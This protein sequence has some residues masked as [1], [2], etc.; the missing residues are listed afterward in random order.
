MSTETKCYAVLSSKGPLEPTTIK[1][2]SCGP[3]DIAVS[4]KYAGICHS[5]IHT[6][7]EE[8]G[9]IKFPCVPGH[10]IGGIV[11]AVGGNVKKFKAGDVVGVGCMV[12]SCRSCACCKAS[13]E[14]YCMTGA[15]YTYNGTAKYPHML[16][17][18][19]E[20]GAVTYGGYSQSIVVD[21]EFVVL[22]PTN[23]NLAAATPLLCAGIT[24]YSPMNKFGLK[25]FHK[26]GVVGL[27]GLGHMAVKF[28]KAFGCHTTVISRGSSKKENCLKEL[29]AHAFLDSTS[30]EDMAAAANSFDF[31]LDT[32]SAHHDLSS[33]ISLLRLDGKIIL[34]GG[35]VEP[36]QFGNFSL[37]TG[38]KSIGGSLI[39]G[40]KETQEM[41]D[42]CGRNDIT[43]DIEMISA[44]QIN[45]AY[46]RVLKSDVKYR[47][48]IDCAT[49]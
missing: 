20:G 5:D 43:C 29:G 42:F 40:I 39:G 38:R 31:I 7:K 1:R 13:E 6:A 34:V 46:E 10:E 9:P 2:R 23:L 41:L 17:Y 32:V 35:V 22:M 16:E 44:N 47:F 15:V 3:N 49:I 25:P 18:T 28:G 33:Y 21:Q 48:V 24:V 19:P 8:W 4:I 30:S 12:D 37:I 14:Q 11:V 45:E 26:F 27:G 36:M